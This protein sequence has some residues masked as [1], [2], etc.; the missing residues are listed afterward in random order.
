M[1][2]FESMRSRLKTTT[3]VPKLSNVAVINELY[4]K[5]MKSFNL[6]YHL[7]PKERLCLQKKTRAA[8]HISNELALYVLVILFRAC[9]CDTK[10]A[11][12]LIY[13]LFLT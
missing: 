2:A 10:S 3:Y 8:C 7:L 1:Y 13:F 9:D 12:I 11:C 6:D 5:L 4:I